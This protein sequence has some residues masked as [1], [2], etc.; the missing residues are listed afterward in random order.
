[1]L[2]RSDA[3]PQSGRGFSLRRRGVVEKPGHQRDELAPLRRSQ[4]RQQFVLDRVEDR[5]EVAQL[6]ATFRGKGDDVAALVLGVD[7]ALDQVA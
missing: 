1:M 7:R 3:P 2:P 4:W 6:L 5:V